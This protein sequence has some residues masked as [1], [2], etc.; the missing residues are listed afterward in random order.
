MVGGAGGQVA[1][2]R[3]EEDPRDVG[4]VGEEFAHGDDGG[5]VAALHHF[6]DVDVALWGEG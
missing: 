4:V 1:D 3:G 2:V 6:P 5:E